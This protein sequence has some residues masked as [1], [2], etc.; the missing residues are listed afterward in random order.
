MANGKI[1]YSKPELLDIGGVGEI[2]Y[3]QP[4]CTTG[5]S[6]DWCAY[7]GGIQD[8]CTRGTVAIYGC[9]NGD[10]AQDKSTTCKNG[11]TAFPMPS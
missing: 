3:G 6:F 9:G 4:N 5:Y 2:A 7:G 8:R 11:T 1:G 10:I